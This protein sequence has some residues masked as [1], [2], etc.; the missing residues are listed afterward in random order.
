MYLL[1]FSI[2]TGMFVPTTSSIIRPS[3]R[4]TDN[5]HYQNESKKVATEMNKNFGLQVASNVREKKKK[6]KPL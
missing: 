3:F 5:I 4:N 6:T 2:N 1:T